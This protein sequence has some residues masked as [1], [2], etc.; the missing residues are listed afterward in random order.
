MKSNYLYEVVPNC[1]Q[2]IINRGVF[3]KN[4]EFERGSSSSFF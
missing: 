1:Y 4:E 2:L 3:P